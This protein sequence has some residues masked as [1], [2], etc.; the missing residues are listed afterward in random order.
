MS[1]SEFKQI[2]QGNL[3]DPRSILRNIAIHCGVGGTA[4]TTANSLN[5]AL[6]GVTFRGS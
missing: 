3:Q 4:I 2:A 1:L 5:T 6:G